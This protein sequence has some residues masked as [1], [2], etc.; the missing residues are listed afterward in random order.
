MIVG[1]GAQVL[2]PINV[3]K[4]ARI[5]ANAVVTR[6]VPEGATMTGIPARAQLIEA[7]TYAKPFM[8]YGTPCSQRFDP[9]T[10]KLELLRCELE[11]L[12]ARLDAL[13]GER[14][15]DDSQQAG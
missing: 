11:T 13:T 2:G 3:G 10:Q 1:S 12:R 4:R 15:R 8:P 7:T 14:S 9:D 6:E 5:G